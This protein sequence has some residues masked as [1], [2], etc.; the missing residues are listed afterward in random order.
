MWKR[1]FLRFA[2]AA[3]LVLFLVAAVCAFVDP[4]DIYGGPRIAG[5]TAV[6]YKSEFTERMT[7]PVQM[8]GRPIETLILGNSK[9]D[10]AIDPAVWRELTGETGVY[11]AA[12]RDGRIGEARKLLEHAVG[13]HPELRRVI[14][15]V[16]YESFRDDRR[17]A[18]E[19]DDVQAAAGHLTPANFAKT[20]FSQDALRDSLLTVRENRRRSAEPVHP[21]FSPDG[22]FHESE[23]AIIFGQEDDFDKN[24]HGL[25]RYHARGAAARVTVP[26]EELAAIRDICAARGIE[27]IAFVPPVHPLHAAAY[28]EDADDYA[29][30]L[31][32]TAAIVPLADFTLAPGTD[33]DEDYWDTAHMKDSLGRRILA[34]LAGSS[35]D[36]IGAQPLGFVR[37]TAENAGERA[38]ETL[39]DAAGWLAAHPGRQAELAVCDGWAEII[40]ETDV[41]PEKY[42]VVDDPG[43]TAPSERQLAAEEA[44]GGTGAA[45][46]LLRFG[47]IPYRARDVRAV[48]AVLETPDG[49]TLY[50]R[51]QK[52]RDDD[53]SRQELLHDIRR[54]PCRCTLAAPAPGSGDLHLLVLLH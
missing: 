7:K 49:R 16:D 29:A 20:L 17:E 44:A 38:R 51:V 39:A 30:W 35:G 2:L 13:G 40:P 24:L 3:A 19:F 25:L 43:W 48:Y 22:K 47:S 23:L 4:Y 11:D 52:E 10:F 50:H 27:L 31:R 45:G 26:Y 18:Y 42:I 28:A 9:A 15:A 32:R 53:I 37:V 12:L 54:D 5:L 33:G 46:K 8:N 21:V 41:P 6:P 34:A 1:F 36:E 14:L